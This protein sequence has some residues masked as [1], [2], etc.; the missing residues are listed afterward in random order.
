[1]T[2]APVWPCAEVTGR[3]P[4]S[5]EQRSTPWCYTGLPGLPRKRCWPGSGGS[6]CP[7]TRSRPMPDPTGTTIASLG[8]HP[9]RRRCGPDPLPQ[10]RS[11]DGLA[12]PSLSMGHGIRGESGTT[13]PTYLRYFDRRPRHRAAMGQVVT[14]TASELEGCMGGVACSDGIGPNLI[15][16]S[17]VIDGTPC[18]GTQRAV[19]KLGLETDIETTIWIRTGRR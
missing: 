5:P 9:D 1:M 3:R 13:D 12:G 15:H 16:R 14:S 18:A 8:W 7:H 17:M 4:V 10:G 6:S 19:C 11:Y 2:F